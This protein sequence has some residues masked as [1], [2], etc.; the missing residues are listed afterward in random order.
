MFHGKH[1]TGF[2]GL[3]GVQGG[4]GGPAIPGAVWSHHSRGLP[5][6]AVRLPRRTL[7]PAAWAGLGRVDGGAGGRRRLGRALR[8]AGRAHRVPGAPVPLF[9]V[10]RP[11][12]QTA[13][14]GPAAS[15]GSSLPPARPPQCFTRNIGVPGRI[16]SRCKPPG[17]RS[18]SAPSLSIPRSCPAPRRPLTPRGLCPLWPWLYRRGRRHLRGRQAIALVASEGPWGQVGR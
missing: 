12:A 9:L 7:P 1:R 14:P 16:Q 11:R 6:L 15:Q 10:K 17:F 13:D 2:P 8:A 18:T 3:C 5:A 4:R